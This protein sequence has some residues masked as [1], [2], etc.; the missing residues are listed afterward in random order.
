MCSSHFSNADDYTCH[1]QYSKRINNYNFSTIVPG[2]SLQV[3]NYV[4]SNV[5]LIAPEPVSDLILLTAVEGTGEVTV[6]W[7]AAGD[8][9]GYGIGV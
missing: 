6:G 1:E 3:S 2:G 8:D 7:T 9:P 5:D 4:R